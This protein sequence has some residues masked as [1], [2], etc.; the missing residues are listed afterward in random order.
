MG[1]SRCIRWVLA[2]APVLKMLLIDPARNYFFS[3]VEEDDPLM[4][5]AASVGML[6]PERKSAFFGT[7][8][9]S[10]KAQFSFY[11]SD[12]DALTTSQ[13]GLFVDDDSV[14]DITNST[15]MISSD[16]S[17]TSSLH[18]PSFAGTPKRLIKSGGP[19]NRQKSVHFG[20]NEDGAPAP[21][22]SAPE[23][24]PRNEERLSDETKKSAARETI[25]ETP[26]RATTS[27]LLD[28]DGDDLIPPG[29]EH[30]ASSGHAAPPKIRRRIMALITAP[31]MKEEADALLT[32]DSSRT[33]N[34]M[35]VKYE[36]GYAVSYS[37]SSGALDMDDQ[38]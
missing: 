23:M 8:G 13:V 24:S 38:D 9:E 3:H 26:G 6:T 2:V 10:A 20:L 34:L 16:V 21:T 25:V 11:R 1:Y 5:Y 30:E 17:S 36:D 19:P 35:D 4:N 37:S 33:P 7:E 32:P 18:L 29:V 31:A 27:Q 14:N 12:S 22:T 15:S 28:E